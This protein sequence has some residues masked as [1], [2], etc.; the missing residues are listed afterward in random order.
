V[1]LVNKMFFGLYVISITAFGYAIFIHNGMPLERLQ[2]NWLPYSMM[3]LGY[4]CFFGLFW[5]MAL[6]G[7]AIFPEREQ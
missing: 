4:H 5:M 3:V 1:K 7:E 2:E 6:L